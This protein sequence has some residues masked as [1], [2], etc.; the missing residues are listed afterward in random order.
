MRRHYPLF[1]IVCLLI[2]GWPTF[3]C[4]QAQQT[5]GYEVLDT[6]IAHLSDYLSKKDTRIANIRSQ[7]DRCTDDRTR[8][9]LLLNLYTELSTYNSQK[10]FETLDEC[11]QLSKKLEKQ[12]LER[13]VEILIGYQKA[14]DGKYTEALALL[15]SIDT[16]KLSQRTLENHLFARFYAIT[17]MASAE[18]SK[19]KSSQMLDTAEK[20][21][22]QYMKTA[23]KDARYYQLQVMHMLNGIRITAALGV[24]EN[25]QKVVTAGTPAY[26]TMARYT[27][28]C[29]RKNAEKQLP[30]LITAAKAEIECAITNGDALQALAAMLENNGDKT[31]AQHYSEVA[32]SLRTKYLAVEEKKTADAGADSNDDTIDTTTQPSTNASSANS[33]SNHVNTITAVMTALLA[34]LLLLAVIVI[35]KVRGKARFAEDKL[36]ETT[37]MVAAMRMQLLQS[38]KDVVMPQQPKDIT[39]KGSRHSDKKKQQE[40]PESTSKEMM[41]LMSANTTLKKQNEA[42]SAK[43][44]E[45]VIKT[46]D[47]NEKIKNL[48][49]GLPMAPA[50]AEESK[51]P[52]PVVIEKEVI[53]EVEVVKEV[54]KEVPVVKE[55]IKEVPVIKEVVKEVV[56][57]APAIAKE[58]LAV[59][60][61]ARDQM[62]PLMVSHCAKHL[63]DKQMEDVYNRFD[64]IILKTF[65]HFPQEFNALLQPENRQ[66]MRHRGE[67]TTEMRMAALIRLGITNSAQIADFL[68]LSA[69]TVY[70]YR[71]RLKSKALGDREQFEEMIKRIGES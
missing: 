59:D 30:W 43:V 37:N 17:R 25:W 20:L 13:R 58:T 8:Y 52:D 41:D 11:I 51:T 28:V 46:R 54:V 48:S 69:N 5:T 56:K 6:A 50:P 3:V 9:D 60:S 32:K 44:T 67:L 57:N 12:D 68:H 33:G 42:L 40:V 61:K 19:E 29:N 22:L 45:L 71:A 27:A 62:I 16:E 31:R 23:D 34:V 49:E 14:L 21:A 4:A 53:K 24:C 66:I 64:T 47:L 1:L 70:N 63:T 38:G 10:A 65:P 35:V 15:D 7:V 36:I 26:A 18:K 55:V 2:I 39:K